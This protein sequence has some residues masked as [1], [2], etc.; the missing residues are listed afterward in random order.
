MLYRIVV[1]SQIQLPNAFHCAAMI[2]KYTRVLGGKIASKNADAKNTM[3]TARNVRFANAIS[4]FA[5]DTLSTFILALD[6]RR[7]FICPVCA[8][9]RYA[10]AIPAIQIRVRILP[11]IRECFAGHNL[12]GTPFLR[13]SPPS[14]A[15]NSRMLKSDVHSN[16]R[17]TDTPP[18]IAESNWEQVP[19][20]LKEQSAPLRSGKCLTCLGLNYVGRTHPSS[21]ALSLQ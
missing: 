6:Y 14:R 17:R 18:T 20:H 7:Y 10:F 16:E 19:M 4:L 13:S 8:A 12:V 3:N 1:F 15:R 2:Q 11:R 9:R 21:L 5:P